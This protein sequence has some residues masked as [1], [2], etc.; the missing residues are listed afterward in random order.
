MVGFVDLRV[1][2]HSK[3]KRR[4]SECSME[5]EHH[6]GNLCIETTNHPTS[7]K[8]DVTTVLNSTRNSVSI[9]KFKK[10]LP[11]FEWLPKYEWK[12]WLYD[13]VVAGITM[14]SLLIPQSAA[15]SALAGVPTN[16][17]MYTSVVSAA[18]CFIF[19]SSSR[20]N[21]GPVSI[22]AIMVAEAVT[23]LLPKIT[24]LD[25]DVAYLEIVFSLS[26]TCGIF[27]ILVS[28]CRVGNIIST[29]LSDPVMSAVT[30]GG[31]LL[32]L[33]SQVGKLLG[34]N[35]P[36]YS[37]PFQ[38]FRSWAYVFLHLHETS[39]QTTVLGISAV[40]FLLCLHAV[41][42]K[43]KMRFPIPIELLTVIVFLGLSA[44]INAEGMGV[45][46]VG[47]IS[48]DLPRPSMP[49][50]SHGVTFGDF[51]VES[52]G[53]VLVMCVIGI[54]LANT[55]AK[56]FDYSIDSDQEVLAY[57]MANMVGSF[58]MCF[59]S[60]VSLSRSSV[61]V[62]VG[63]H[64]PMHQLVTASLMLFVQ[65][66]LS[67]LLATM[68][69][70]C[71][72]AIVIVS[73]RGLLKQAKRPKELWDIHRQDSLLWLISY[74]LTICL[75]MQ[76]GTIGSMC[77]NACLILW[78]V[79]TPD[80]IELGLLEGTGVYRNAKR[81]NN[82][83]LFPGIKVLRIDV[84]E[85]SHLNRKQFETQIKSYVMPMIDEEVTRRPWFAVLDITAVAY[86]DTS[87]LSNLQEVT[88]W[89]NGH[90]TRLLIVGAKYPVR[91]AMAD[92]GLTSTID[93][94]SFFPRM[95]PAIDYAL[96]LQN[97]AYDIQ[98]QGRAEVGG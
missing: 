60:G 35:V 61:L 8:I 63:C 34:I 73:L 22:I 40:V 76:W 45:N 29:V 13:D 84:G 7:M 47:D 4:M 6:V 52:I 54:S 94:H 86:I 79:T 56:K 48:K 36:R 1:T 21:V 32:V 51:V 42:G 68:P 25:E 5:N 46:V 16:I 27:L 59:P 57:G 80:V 31:A 89:L 44:L 88:E 10:L 77:V 50:F 18:M 33:T 53:L 20:T 74:I 90:D 58:F 70:A 66:T 28:V 65:S 95:Q 82:L 81:Y 12:N 92:F 17:G 98:P 67:F 3:K 14:V 78:R 49:N 62:A 11:I 97:G 91:D 93:F 41:N 75:G 19:S 24:G 38:I 37:Q 83:K 43:L 85:L 87:S 64:S 71:L 39:W 55:F 96:S 26:F 23:N 30:C 15:F 2:A 72:S 69:Y 9:S